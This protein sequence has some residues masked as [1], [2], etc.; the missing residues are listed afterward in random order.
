MS[1][2]T[3]LDHSLRTQAHTDTNGSGDTS[4]TYI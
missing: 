2:G 4:V 1:S 3:G